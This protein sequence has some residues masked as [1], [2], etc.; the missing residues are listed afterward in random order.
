MSFLKMTYI[1][2]DEKELKKWS[3]LKRTAYL[4][5][6]LLIYFVVHDAAEILLIM[7]LEL[8]LTAGNQAAEGE[9][10]TVF[11]S[12]ADTLKGILGGLSALTGTAAVYPALKRELTPGTE[13]TKSMGKDTA[14][15]GRSRTVN[16]KQ[17]T[18]YCFLAAL[19]MCLAVGLN[20]FFYQT[21]LTGSSKAFEQIQQRQY[22]VQFTAGIVLYGVISPLAEETVFRGLLYN[23]MRRCFGYSLALIVSSLLFGAYHGNWVQTLYGSILGLA[24]AYTYGLYGSFAAPLLFHGVANVSVYALTYRNSLASLDRKTVLILGAAMLF[25]AAVIFLYITKK[26]MRGQKRD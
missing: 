3:S 15:A 16:E 1:R 7:I 24:I 20:I 26:L 10:L 25:A 8:V 12:G 6:P 13:E 9:F 4:L 19:A 14:Q 23:R 17:V 22:G 18:S 21:G 5:L 11:V 2:W